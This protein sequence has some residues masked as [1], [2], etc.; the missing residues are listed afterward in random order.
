MSKGTPSFGKHQKITHIRCKRCGRHA[1]HIR[2]KKC[3][4]CGFGKTSKIRNEKWRWKKVNRHERK[5]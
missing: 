5:K 3:A 1:Y 4:A 2:K